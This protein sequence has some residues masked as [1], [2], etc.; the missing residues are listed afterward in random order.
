MDKDNNGRFCDHDSF[1][2]VEP[3]YEIE[4][5]GE[6]V[7]EEFY[8]ENN[9]SFPKFLIEETGHDNIYEEFSG[10]YILHNHDLLS[11]A[12]QEIRIKET[13]ESTKNI[14]DQD[15]FPVWYVFVRFK[16]W[17]SFALWKPWARG[18]KDEDLRIKTKTRGQVFF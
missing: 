14:C 3:F 12:T 9:I 13:N 10:F 5:E 7:E 4:D 8:V 16:L 18:I 2:D 1:Y 17:K 15:Y 6:F 11:M